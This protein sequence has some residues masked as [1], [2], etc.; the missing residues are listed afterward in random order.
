MIRDDFRLFFVFL[1]LNIVL[2]NDN[3]KRNGY[4]DTK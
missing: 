2:Y 1:L 3:N 4:G